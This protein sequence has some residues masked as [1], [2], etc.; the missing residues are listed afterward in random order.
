MRGFE[1]LARAKSVL[2][3]GS[4]GFVVVDE[5]EEVGNPRN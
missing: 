2:S 1:D 3:E 5:V 4:L